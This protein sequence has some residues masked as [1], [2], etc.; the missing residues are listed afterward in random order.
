MTSI[1]PFAAAL[2]C[3]VFVGEV[4]PHY[5]KDMHDPLSALELGVGSCAARAAVASACLELVG[6][7]A[8]FLI[9][10][11]HGSR[12]DPMHAAAGVVLAGGTGA[13]VVDSD[14]TAR[15]YP[16]LWM[17]RTRDEY[18]S[19]VPDVGMAQYLKRA[20]DSVAAQT[21]SF[22]ALKARVQKALQLR[23]AL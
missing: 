14:N 4:L 19:F 20:G 2:D 9:H 15:T 13:L 22:N 3:S 8:D 18:E 11:K 12:D 23:T 5:D 10:N 7:K 17:P 16:R 6:L 1:R 21:F